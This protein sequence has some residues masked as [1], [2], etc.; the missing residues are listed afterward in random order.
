MPHGGWVALG[1]TLQGASHRTQAAGVSR[2]PSTRD[3]SCADRRI[4]SCASRGR[5]PHIKRDS[6]FS[7]AGTGHPAP[8]GG[9][10]TRQ[11]MPHGSCRTY[12]QARS[13]PLPAEQDLGERASRRWTTHAWSRHT[14]PACWSR[15]S[16]C[17]ASR[18]T[19]DSWCTRATSTPSAF[20]Y[21]TNG[22]TGCAETPRAA[23]SPASALFRGEA[24]G[25]PVLGI[26]A[27]G[28]QVPAR[29]SSSSPSA[30][31]RAGLVREKGEGDSITT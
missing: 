9:G 14:Q 30:R 11:V 17:G 24:V 21:S 13:V 18:S 25:M 4:T 16:E 28:K 3:C 26:A 12:S 29:L 2:A 1:M 10:C 27:E 7:T 6:V 20:R 5:G 8:H 22:W 31:G 15:L 19:T 23:V